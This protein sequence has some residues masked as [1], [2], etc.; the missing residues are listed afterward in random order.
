[1]NNSWLFDGLNLGD[2]CVSIE[3]GTKKLK[4]TDLTCGPGHGIRYIFRY[5][6]I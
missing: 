3:D 2:D 4:I 6:T 1:M 5:T